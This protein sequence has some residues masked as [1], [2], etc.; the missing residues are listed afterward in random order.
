MINNISNCGVLKKVALFIAFQNL[1]LLSLK[2][3]TMEYWKYLIIAGWQ[4]K[5]TVNRGNLSRRFGTEMKL[6]CKMIMRIV[7]MIG[8]FENMIYQTKTLR[9][10][11]VLLVWV[12]TWHECCGWRQFPPPD[13]CTECGRLDRLALERLDAPSER[14]SCRVAY[15]G[16]LPERFFK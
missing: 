5:S 16:G 4:R 10:T 11:H 2:L 13:I 6:L 3:K 15:R 8:F 9:N 1:N 14:V 7:C 12:L